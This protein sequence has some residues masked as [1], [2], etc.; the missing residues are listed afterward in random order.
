MLTDEGETLIL[1]CI[2]CDN[3]PQMSNMNVF[4]QVWVGL[5]CL[6][7]YNT[8]TRL[9]YCLHNLFVFLVGPSVYVV[10]MQ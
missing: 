3:I 2:S 8:Y 5:R 7:A 4:W 10:G 1:D 9:R 6:F